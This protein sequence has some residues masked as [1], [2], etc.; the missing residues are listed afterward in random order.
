MLGDIEKQNYFK[1]RV[2]WT[3][4]ALAEVDILN[5]KRCLPL[6]EILAVINQKMVIFLGFQR[7]IIP[8]LFPNLVNI[9]GNHPFRQYLLGRMKLLL[10]F[11]N[12]ESVLLNVGFEDKSEVNDYH[13]IVQNNSDL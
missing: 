5:Q 7:P 4:I 10:Q 1:F 6:V 3:R 11:W 8:L 9:P 13:P 12:F 2:V